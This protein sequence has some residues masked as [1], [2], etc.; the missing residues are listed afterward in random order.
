MYIY[1]HQFKDL[2][3]QHTGESILLVQI[4]DVMDIKEY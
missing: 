1:I 4:I 2:S 3:Q